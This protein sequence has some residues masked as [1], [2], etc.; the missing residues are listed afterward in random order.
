[1]SHLNEYRGHALVTNT[2]LGIGAAIASRL[3][4]DDRHVT[5]LDRAEKT[6]S[7][8]YFASLTHDLLDAD[9][10]RSALVAIEVDPFVH[11]AGFMRVGELGSLDLAAG[12]DMWGVNV[13]AAMSLASAYP[14]KGEFV[15]LATATPM[16]VDSGRGSVPRVSPDRPLCPARGNRCD[17]RVSV[18]QRGCR[19]HGP[20]ARDLWWVVSVICRATPRIQAPQQLNHIGR[21]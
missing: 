20:T 2:S 6:I 9:A 13:A 18:V 17:H 12:T 14:A 3:L 8:P 15:L 11:A 16:L 19:D 7:A 10:V 21:L 1:M 4:H 5:G